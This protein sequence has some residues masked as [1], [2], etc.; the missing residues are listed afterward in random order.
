M[1]RIMAIGDVTSP[2]AAAALADK[3]WSIR[4]E[5]RIDFVIVNAENAGFII[6]PSTDTAHALLNA[7]AD[8]LSGGNHMIQNTQLHAMLDSDTRVLRPANL[9]AAACGTGYTIAEAKGYRV[10]VANVLGRVHMDPPSD[11]PYTAIETILRREEGNY[12]LS[13]LD[14]HAEATGEKV[15]L[16]LYFDGSFSAIFGTHTHVPTADLQI[17]PAGTGY[18]TDLGMCGAQGG[19]LGIA[20]ESIFTRYRNGMPARFSPAEGDLYADAVIFSIDEGSSHTEKIERV[21]LSL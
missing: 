3:L 19:V 14:I 8:V 2:K 1:L 16:A 17:M 4:K 10:L 7:G 12:D 6:G 15:A 21:K 18:V 11:S 5:H 20:K 9:P 13:L